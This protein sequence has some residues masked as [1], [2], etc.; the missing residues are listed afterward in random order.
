MLQSLTRMQGGREGESM[1]REEREEVV[2]K[3]GIGAVSKEEE[4][5]EKGRKMFQWLIITC[6]IMSFNYT[7][8]ATLMLPCP[9]TVW[10]EVSVCLSVCLLACLCVCFSDH[11]L[12]IS[13]CLSV[14]LFI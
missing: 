7:T 1:H 5:E 3:G 12:F 4:K 10:W 14:C 6:Q 8:P 2:G 9:L 11:P 13:L